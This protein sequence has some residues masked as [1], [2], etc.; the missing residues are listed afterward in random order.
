MILLAFF[1]AKEAIYKILNINIYLSII[2]IIMN[3]KVITLNLGYFENTEN[4]KEQ[5]YYIVYR[6]SHL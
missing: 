5:Y 4:N 1:L 2:Y 3:I 6:A